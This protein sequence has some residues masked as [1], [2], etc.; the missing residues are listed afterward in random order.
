[1]SDPLLDVVGLRV[2]FHT[3][4]GVV[5]AVDG[6]SFHLDEGD[7]LGLVGESGCGKSVTALSLLRLVPSP[8][9]R[10]R[11]GVIRYRGLDLLTAEDRELRR[12]RGLEVGFVFQE[13]GAA[14]DPV[15]RI[16]DQ[17]AE[18]MRVHLGLGRA[19]ARA[20][21]IGLLEQLGF[22]DAA[23]RADDFPHQLSGG[24]QQR[25]MLAIALACDPSLI[26]AD[27]P[28]TALDVTLQA[29]ILAL[30]GRIRRERGTS[31]LLI[32]HDL[33]VVAGV[34]D[35]V[36]V[37][38][39]GRAVEQA[40]ASTLFHGARHPYTRA[41]LAC[42]PRL[43][44]SGDRRLPAIPG[45]PPAPGERMDG[46][47]FHPRCEHAV[48]RCRAEVPAERPAGEDHVVACH[49]WEELV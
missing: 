15:F 33:D 43:A 44:G 7:A 31:L 20:R 3:D 34:V 22:E 47:P 5:R 30:L 13:P 46:C 48:D 38:Y 35:R 25:A 11:D 21:A 19:E 14:L 10:Y 8:P 6:L 37:M 29:Q 36:V 12:V 18:G 41:L 16:G 17:V 42:R 23:R 32:S 4:L 2:E 45:A 39:A 9:G 49:R 24:M 40:S 1:M 28:T 26:I 27:E